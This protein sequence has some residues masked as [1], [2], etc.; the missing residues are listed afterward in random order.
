MKLD[1]RAALLEAN[2]RQYAAIMEQAAEP[3][4]SPGYRKS[5]A[6]MLADPNGWAKRL[7]RPL[8]KK[9]LQ[10][11]ACILLAFSLALGALM[12]V[13]PTVRAAVLNWF[14]EIREGV[15]SYT[16]TDMAEQ[17]APPIWRPTWVPENF[18]L[19]DVWTTE[20]QAGWNFTETGKGD[21]GKGLRIMCFVPNGRVS[22]DT[23]L[24]DIQP[25]PTT[26]QGNPAA[27]YAGVHR[28]QLV[29]ENQEGYLFWLSTSGF[30]DRELLEK[31]GE[32]MEPYSGT[33][34]SAFAPAWLPEGHS[35]GCSF[36]GVG[37]QQI[38]RNGDVLTFQY[39]TNPPCAWET[40]Q[41][42]A[43]ET[44]TVQGSEGMLWEA[45][46]PEGQEDPAVEAGDVIIAAG[47]SHGI[48]EEGVLIWT[49]AE[50]DTAFQIRG[51]LPKE[52]LLRIAESVTAVPDGGQTRE[53]R[54][55]RKPS[56]KH[57]ENHRKEGSS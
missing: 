21:R 46:V 40:D 10:T 2:M 22:G 50:M 25:I 20:E 28:D 44:V 54:N 42:R 41:S 19:R 6:R 39:V 37:Q 49:D 17:L 1:L 8:W 18:V 32:S 11:A 9:T 30:S 24:P 47:T 38:L 12:G 36:A 16:S 34:A 4:F 31:L 43:G 3:E 55:E 51:I 35:T 56:V 7:G 14:R 15:V 52:D 29:W 23:G 33:A 26:V 57:Y 5:C 53:P 48:E 27:Y 45:V 13:S